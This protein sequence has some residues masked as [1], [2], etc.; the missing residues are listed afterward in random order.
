M[1]SQSA[2]RTKTE[3]VSEEI[4]LCV[5]CKEPT[6]YKISD[7]IDKRRDYIEGMG[8]VCSRCSNTHR[9]YKSNEVTDMLYDI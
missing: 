2:Q 3:D 5:L 8:Q 1:D 4:D 6:N 7:H 9:Q